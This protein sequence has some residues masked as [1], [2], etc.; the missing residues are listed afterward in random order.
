[1]GLRGFDGGKTGQQVTKLEPKVGLVLFSGHC[2]ERRRFLVFPNCNSD[3]LMRTR[4]ACHNRR[5]QQQQQQ[6]R[7]SKTT[8]TRMDAIIAS[9][10]GEAHDYRVGVEIRAQSYPEISP[11]VAQPAVSS[12]DYYRSYKCSSFA[13]SS[14]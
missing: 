12:V 3:D 6:Q 5:H 7:Q 8:H 2:V 13:V 4:P 14:R 11:N 10:D 9:G 1:M